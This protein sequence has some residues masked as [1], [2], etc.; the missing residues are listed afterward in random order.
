V[1]VDQWIDHENVTATI[2]AHLPG[3]YSGRALVS[4]L[5]GEENFSGKLPYTVPRNESDYSVY[6]PCGRAGPDDDFP[7]CDFAEGVYLDYR[8]FDARNVTPRFAFGFGMSYTT[9]KYSGLRIT[10][11]KEL[12]AA[13]RPGNVFSFG[14]L[15]DALLTVQVDIT[16]TGPVAGEEVAQLY[17]GIPNRPAKQL[18]GFEKTRIEPGET[19][20]VEFVVTRR[21]MSIWEVVS[22][23]WLVQE[24]EYVVHVGGSSQDIRAVGVVNVPCSEEV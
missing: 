5:Y 8:D 14:Q 18:R 23:E 12:G 9:Y 20:T 1:L 19:S 7:Q 3:Q 17:L 21:D 2:F 10:P 16:N 24:G 13:T 6:A 11:R 22:Q 4:L 15:W